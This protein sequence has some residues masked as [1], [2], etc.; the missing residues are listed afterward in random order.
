MSE[1]DSQWPLRIVIPGKPIGKGRPRFGKGRVY[2]PA[3]TVDYENTVAW[4]AK[5]LMHG[6]PII[7]GAVR[8]TITCSFTGKDRGW[9]VSKP[10][11]DNLIKSISDALNGIVY[12]D[13]QQIS[14]ISFCKIIGLQ[15]D[16][17]ISVQPL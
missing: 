16:V 7:T 14:V 6:R 9:H 2:T 10:D 4:Y 3:K 11:A 5:T 8:L 15:E 17:N 1:S 12:K 13:D